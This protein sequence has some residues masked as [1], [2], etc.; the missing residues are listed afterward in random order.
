MVENIGNK[1]HKKKSN[2]KLILEYSMSSWM[3]F[4]QADWHNYSEVERIGCGGQKLKLKQICE[5]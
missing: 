3:T 2:S 1:F 4:H 5:K